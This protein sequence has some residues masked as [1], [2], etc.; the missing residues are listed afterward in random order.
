M[1]NSLTWQW[2]GGQREEVIPGMRRGGHGCRGEELRWHWERLYISVHPQ[3]YIPPHIHRGPLSI[4]LSSICPQE[5][6]CPSTYT[7]P[8]YLFI[9]PPTY[10]SSIHPPSFFLSPSLPTQVSTIYPISLPRVI[11]NFQHF[12]MSLTLP[13]PSLMF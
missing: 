7:L 8:V 2:R 9:H 4:N 11:P 3:L 13:F 5:P 6:I 1:G 12:P 10:T